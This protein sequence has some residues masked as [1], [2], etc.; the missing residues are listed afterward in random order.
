MCDD[1][2]YKTVVDYYGPLFQL[3]VFLDN[4]HLRY[5]EQEWCRCIGVLLQCSSLASTSFDSGPARSWTQDLDCW[6]SWVWRMTVVDHSSK[7]T[8]LRNRSIQSRRAAS[9]QISTTTSYPF[10]SWHS[11][12]DCQK[13]KRRTA[14]HWSSWQCPGSVCSSSPH[15]GPSQGGR[16]HQW[17]SPSCVCALPGGM[18]FEGSLPEGSPPPCPQDG[19]VRSMSR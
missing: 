14:E 2:R 16:Y 17:L 10:W 9:Q 3:Q 5:A 11:L 8:V 18:Q 15:E 4:K 1:Q 19:P 7:T 6:S 13:G 12:G